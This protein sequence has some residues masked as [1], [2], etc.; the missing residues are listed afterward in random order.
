M[1]PNVLL[2][3]ILPHRFLSRIVYQATRWE[4]APWKNFLIG[5]IVKRYDVDMSQAA[6]PDP[7][8][9]QHFNAFFTRKLKPDARRA[10]PD[11]QAIVSPA[12]GRIS[13]SGRIRDGR[14]FQAKG[15]EYT[16]AELLGDEAAAAPFRNGSFVTIYLSPRDY[17]R[18]HMPLEGELTGTTHVP[19]RIF[20]VA[21]FAVEAIPRLFA[22][23]ERLVCHFDGAHGPFVSVMVGAILV[24]SVATVWDGLAIPPYAH[25]IRRNDCRGRGV[26]LERF[27][28]MARFNMGSTVILLLPEG[29]ELD[30]LQ[31]QQ[32]VVVGQRL[33]RWAG[34]A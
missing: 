12:D 19:G 15:Q 14:I 11:P 6:Q 32:Q 27:G 26:R 18:V 34:E 30:E 2:Q 21:P 3:Y 24:S 28:E 13:Q 9:Y 25:E 17:H 31:P 8:A 29:Y 22:R 1:K 4:W 16:A 33:G 20:S 23:N 10:D 7:F 5:E